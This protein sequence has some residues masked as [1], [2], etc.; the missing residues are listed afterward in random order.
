MATSFKREVA[1]VLLRVVAVVAT[2]VL[3]VVSLTWL[4]ETEATISDGVC[5]IAFMPIEGT[6]LPFRG[7]VDEPLITTPSDVESF[8]KTAENEP[9]ITGI[10][11]EINSPGGTPVAS[12]RIAEVIRNTELPVVAVVGDVAASGGYLAAAAADHIIA[13]PMSDVGSIGVNMS[14]VENSKQNEE[15]GLTYVQLTSAEFKD[16]GSPDRPI[17][18]AE[19][20]MFQADLDS[21]HDAFVSLVATYR[22]LDI[23]TVE[24]LANGAS[25]PGTRALESKLID[26]LG[27]FAEARGVMSALIGKSLDETVICDYTPPSLF[28]F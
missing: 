11:F 28:D 21:V 7:L 12:E 5:T 24:A 20:A 26:S 10:I 4:Y 13:S 17:T 27:G 15:E 22:N 8:I 1:N 3:I 2:I 16:A 9:G 23:G 14:Y 6:I 18:D 25:M 19:R